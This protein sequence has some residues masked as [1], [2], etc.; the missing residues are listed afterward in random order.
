MPKASSKFEQ[1]S[2]GSHICGIVASMNVRIGSE[3]RVLLFPATSTNEINCS[4]TTKSRCMS[5][6]MENDN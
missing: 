1:T 3:E 6:A 5:S 4:P 2:S